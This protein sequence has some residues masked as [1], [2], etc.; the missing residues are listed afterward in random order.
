MIEVAPMLANVLSAGFAAI[1]AVAVFLTRRQDRQ[2]R[3]FLLFAVGFAILAYEILTVGRG[4]P[5]SVGIVSLA[6]AM[7]AV[8]IDVLATRD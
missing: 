7:I 6:V 8:L 1:A 5:I 2:G 3:W 4:W